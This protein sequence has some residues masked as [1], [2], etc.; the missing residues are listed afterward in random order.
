MWI[1][2]TGNL[3]PLGAEEE[4]ANRV[5]IRMHIAE[6]VYTLEDSDGVR[7]AEEKAKTAPVVATAVPDVNGN[8]SA[9]IDVKQPEI[10]CVHAIAVRA[11]LVLPD[12][13]VRRSDVINISSILVPDAVAPQ[14]PE[15]L[16]FLG[17]GTFEIGPARDPD[18]AAIELRR[19]DD[20]WVGEVPKEGGTV[21]D[22]WWD[23]LVETVG[24]YKAIARDWS[25][26]RSN[27]C[28]LVIDVPSVPQFTVRDNLKGGFL[29][30][31]TETETTKHEVEYRR[32]GEE[33]W[34]RVEF[35]GRSYNSP[36]LV[37]INEDQFVTYEVRLRSLSQEGVPS[38]WSTIA[39][40]DI[41]PEGENPSL[42]SP[43]IISVSSQPDGL[44]V[45]LSVEEHPEIA[46][47]G[48]EARKAESTSFDWSTTNEEKEVFIPLPEGKYFVRAYCLDRQ[49]GWDPIPRRVDHMR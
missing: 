4:A 21:K 47:Y 41:A 36:T 40:V 38:L 17:A 35:T 1:K 32:E 13:R 9:Q 27:P 20:T 23:S 46:Q 33:S 31:V 12:G 45:T 14:P 25:G 34:T 30:T 42:P 6:D 3:A 8:F 26:N 16:H 29:L 24:R 22:P 5:E 7:E 11:L 48:V 10:G 37:S 49:T 28:W 44:L 2:V 18:V 19:E 15:Y 43:S 39:E